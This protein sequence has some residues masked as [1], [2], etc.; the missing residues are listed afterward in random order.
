MIWIGAAII[1][2]ALLVVIK[3]FNGGCGCGCSPKK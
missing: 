2:I 1:I 3:K